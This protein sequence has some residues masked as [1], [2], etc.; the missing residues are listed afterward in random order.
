MGSTA[1]PESAATCGLWMDPSA[2]SIRR[3]G[4]IDVGPWEGLGKRGNM[5]M[6]VMKKLVSAHRERAL[7]AGMPEV[8]AKLENSKRSQP[9]AAPTLECDP[10]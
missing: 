5:W 3:A 8:G 2:G 7:W 4:E 1:S 10:L 6:R 9:S